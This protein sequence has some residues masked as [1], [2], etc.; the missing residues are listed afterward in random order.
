[1]SRRS[2]RSAALFAVGL[3][4]VALIVG[5]AAPSI[6]TT[7]ESAHDARAEVIDRA[8]LPGSHVGS[9]LATRRAGPDTGP[10]TFLVELATLTGACA[11]AS[12]ATRRARQR[13][14]S[15]R[16]S[17]LVPV[18]CGVRAPPAVGA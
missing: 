16:T 13:E 14:A 15:A 5:R 17:A 4:S 3:V 10:P 8:S 6:A 18:P 11:L 9:L 7:H 2:W 12:L 1:M